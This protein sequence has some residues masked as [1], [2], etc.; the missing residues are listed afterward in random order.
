MRR[1]ALMVV[2]AAVLLGQDRP[3]REMPMSSVVEIGPAT[4]TVTGVDG[5]TAT[6]SASEIYQMPQQTVKTTDH[7]TPVVFQGVRLSDVLSK[8]A[9]PTGEKFHNTAASYYLVAEA[10][11]G[12]K[13]VFAWAELDASFMDKPVYVAIKRDGMPLG[14]KD[15]PFELV[16]TG[17][18]RNARWVRQV[19]A[20]KIR[21]AN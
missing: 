21:Q 9:T 4:F 15:G 1:V 17:E 8:V 20:L 12:Y 18:K 2:A 13:A 6:L 5:A 10:K 11:D 3:K 16:T 14:Q 7:G 19:T